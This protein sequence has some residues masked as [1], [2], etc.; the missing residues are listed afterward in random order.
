LS[1]S[2]KHKYCFKDIASNYRIRL[3]NNDPKPKD[4]KGEQSF[5][6]S[7]GA[8]WPDGQFSFYYSEA[9]K[10]KMIKFSSII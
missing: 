1:R 5:Y 4:Y 10:T 9:L 6:F 3:K 7:R 8:E 2:I